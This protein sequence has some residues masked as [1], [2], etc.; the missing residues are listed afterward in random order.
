MIKSIVRPRIDDLGPT[1]HV[2]N[3]VLPSWFQEARQPLLEYFVADA[4]GAKFPL[5]VKEYTVTF[6]RELLL[7]PEVE[8][9]ITVERIGNSSFVLHELAHQDG[10]L[11][12]E[13]R[14]VYIYIGTDNRP[15]SVPVH[16]RSSLETHVKR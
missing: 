8:I 1:S 11:A 10:Q 2:H 13:S 5:M 6:H 14:V 16:L 15:A 9:E 7:V 4:N 3:T 12:A